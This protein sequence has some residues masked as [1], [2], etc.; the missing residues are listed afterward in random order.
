MVLPETA[1]AV[2]IVDAAGGAWQASLLQLIAQLGPQS[3]LE[4][5]INGGATANMTDGTWLPVHLTPKCSP[6]GDDA[7]AKPCRACTVQM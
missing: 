2:S 4:V 5:Q 6:H 1:R 7:F 3:P